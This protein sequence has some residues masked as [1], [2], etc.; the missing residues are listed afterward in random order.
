MWTLVEACMQ[1]LGWDFEVGM[2]TE[3]AGAGPDFMSNLERWTYSDHA[4]AESEGYGFERHLAEL[5][6]FRELIGDDEDQARIPDPVTMSPEDAARLEL[7]DLL[8]AEALVR[9]TEILGV[10]S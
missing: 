3:E 4:R 2:A 8:E 9:A 10:D 7:D 6:A 1:E 5:A